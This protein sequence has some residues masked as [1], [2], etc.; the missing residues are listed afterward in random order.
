MPNWTDNTLTITGTKEDLQN[1]YNHVMKIEDDEIMFD[2]N[3]IIRMPEGLVGTN[4][5]SSYY[6]F[7]EYNIYDKT[8]TGEK[9]IDYDFLLKERSYRYQ[10][11]EDIDTMKQIYKERLEKYDAF[12]WYNWSTKNWGTKWN[13]CETTII[14]NTENELK[15]FF[16]TAWSSPNPVFNVMVRMFPTLKYVIEIVDEDHGGKG[17]HHTF[18]LWW[19]SLGTV[20]TFTDG[21]GRTFTYDE[22][23]YLDSSED[24]EDYNYESPYGEKVESWYEWDYEF[25]PVKDL[26]DSE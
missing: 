9:E 17:E 16:Q 18:E 13:A 3:T 14:E 23:K 22:L 8:V 7:Y 19:E 4:A 1:F 21:E 2:F 5:D 6:D 11:R 15:I 20:M 10:T 25:V 26:V 12:D 24:D